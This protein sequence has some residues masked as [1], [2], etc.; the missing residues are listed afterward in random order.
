MKKLVGW[1]IIFTTIASA[2]II[3]FFESF[4]LY[5]LLL[6]LFNLIVA[7]RFIQIFDR[8]M[9]RTCQVLL[10]ILFIFSGFVK[11]VDPIGTAYRIEDYFIAYETEGLIPFALMLSVILYAAEFILG[12]LML[13]NIKPRFVSLLIL[14][15]MGLFTLTTFYDA[16]YSPVPDCGCF[17][18]AI[19]LTN[20]QTFYKNLVINVFVLIVFLLRDKI[21]P[22]I[23]N[24]TQWAFGILIIILFVGF[25]IFNYQHLPI[26]DFRPWKI[27]N[28]ML[29][30][31][32]LPVQYYLIYRN[33]ITGEEIEYLSP[34]YPYN[35]PEWVENWEFV[36]QRIV[37]PN[38]IPG[39][40]LSI[41]N[42]EGYDV[43]ESY[44]HNPDFHFYLVMCDLYK[45]D[46]GSFNKIRDLYQNAESEDIS[47]IGLIASQQKKLEELK[48]I[49]PEGMQFFNADDIVLKTIIRSNPGLVLM[50][51]GVVEGKWHYNNL[52]DWKQLRE[53]YFN[54]DSSL[55]LKNKK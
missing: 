39:N 26:F 52:P 38:H 45:T 50:K 40:D 37:D 51:N 28:N 23:S 7:V 31:N 42:F 47:F 24:I 2:C 5:F 11:G 12:A 17:G 14:L 16:L 27:G 54:S 33:K 3:Y 25:E 49:L 32:P 1:V 46:T 36:S 43:T 15:M 22:Y 18:D 44:M 53:E 20:W 21:T 4:N 30:E 48:E 41:I 13:F 6:L 29:P 8:A 10:G 9:I 55:V 34:D 19:I 35:D